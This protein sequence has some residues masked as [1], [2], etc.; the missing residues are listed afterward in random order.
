MK[1]IKVGGSFK[2]GW[3]VKAARKF[4]TKEQKKYK[5]KRNMSI[6]PKRNKGCIAKMASRQLINARKNMFRKGKEEHGWFVAANPV[7]REEVADGQED[8][9]RKPEWVKRFKRKNQVSNRM[10][11]HLLKLCAN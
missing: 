3:E 1:L 5:Y 6:T 11:L 8:E 9:K 2:R 10:R 4:M 7:K